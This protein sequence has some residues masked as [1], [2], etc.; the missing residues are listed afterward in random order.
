M[1][2]VSPGWE[3]SWKAAVRGTKPK[4]MEKLE[5]Q[6]IWLQGRK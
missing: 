3:H 1:G 5:W 6:I 2:R 4:A